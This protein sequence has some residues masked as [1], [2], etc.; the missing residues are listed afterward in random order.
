MKKTKLT[1]EAIDKRVEMLRSG[2]ENLSDSG[3][4]ECG[5][6]IQLGEYIPQFAD[7]IEEHI[8][9]VGDLVEHHSGMICEVREHNS[10]CNVLVIHITGPI[11]GCLE[12]YNQTRLKA[13][14]YKV[15]LEKTICLI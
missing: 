6:P 14:G 13:T 9:E 7:L 4:I 12:Y 2:L 3:D 8:F 15:I 11:T 10:G 1:P 5:K